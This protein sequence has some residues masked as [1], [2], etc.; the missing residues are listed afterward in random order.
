M[1]LSS[2]LQAFLLSL[3][4]VV[5]PLLE[6]FIAQKPQPPRVWLASVIALLGTAVSGLKGMRSSF[7][8][9]DLLGP[10]PTLS[11]RLSLSLSAGRPA[12]SLQTV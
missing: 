4:A 8:Q 1:T 7:S 9:G 6:R 3:T 11:I 5:C 12:T 10:F 2:C